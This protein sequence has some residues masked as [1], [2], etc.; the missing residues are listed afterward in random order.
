[1]TYY[2]RKHFTLDSDPDDITEFELFTVIDDGAVF[3]INGI[4]VLRLGMPD[5]TIQHTTR[6]GRSVGNADYEG[7]F[8][9][10]TE[11]LLAG[12]NVIAVEVHQTSTT[13]SDI[14]FGLGLDAVVA[15]SDESFTD[16]LALLD[17][18]RITELMYHASEN[19]SDFDFVELQNISQTTLN[20]TGVRLRG[21]ID[22]TFPQMFLDPDQYV[23]VVG[24][25]AAFQSIY[26]TSTNVAGE[27]SGS[28]SNGGENIIL[29][30]PWPLEAAILRFEY[31][32]RWYPTTDGGGNSLMIYDP[33][34][35][36]ATWTQPESWQPA[37]PTPGW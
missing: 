27:Y 20:L 11:H 25:L 22:F 4:E 16:A 32:D 9:I 34:A 2:F 21:G 3:Y 6:A 18:L 7:P 24:N 15:T 14:V 30:L 5:G 13:S 17:G 31:S 29:K 1:M 28:L 35:H 19:G 12:D 23:V 33:A 36:P 10:S 37:T 26:R 8:I